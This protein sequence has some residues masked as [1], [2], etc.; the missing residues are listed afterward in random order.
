MINR[1]PGSS[2]NRKWPF[3]DPSNDHETSTSMNKR[4]VGQLVDRKSQSASLPAWQSQS[5]AKLGDEISHNRRS[6]T[7]LSMREAAM[8]SGLDPAFLAIVES[9]DALPREITVSVIKALALGSSTKTSELESAIAVTQSSNTYNTT[10][11]I[12]EIVMTLSSDQFLESVSSFKEFLASETS[13]VLARDFLDKDARISYRIGGLKKSELPTLT[14]YHLDQLES[15]LAGWNISLRNGLGELA[16][17]VT[18]DEG[19]FVFP[20]SLSDFP[21]NAHL[22]MT[23]QA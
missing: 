1:T 7:G 14:F 6:K 2:T 3:R 13:N 12:A 15:P 5:M 19:T 17:G 21:P 18:S 16:S 20:C 23:P 4:M 11:Q 9:G 22:I 8:D 10:G